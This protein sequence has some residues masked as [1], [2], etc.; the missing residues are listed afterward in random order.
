MNPAQYVAD[1]YFF[2]PEVERK[3]EMSVLSGEIKLKK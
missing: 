3:L 1:D 2:K